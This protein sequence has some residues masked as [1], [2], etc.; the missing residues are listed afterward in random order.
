MA[1]MI[2]SVLSPEVKSNAERKIFEWF[3]DSKNT[4]DWIV[5]HSLG[6][7]NHKTV[8]HGEV[9]FFV[10]VPYKGLFAL[11]VKGGRIQRRDGIWTYTNRHGQT[12]SKQRGP[13]EQAWE[14]IHSIID[15]FKSKVDE[16]HS[17]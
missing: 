3:R 10:L 1:K 16:S 14:G 8:I 17:Y 6:I 5:L 9:D 7:S 4:E 12:S 2:P 13:F 15:D 11:E